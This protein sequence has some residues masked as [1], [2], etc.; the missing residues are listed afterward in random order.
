VTGVKQI[1]AKEGFG[2]LYQ[3]LIPTILKQGSNQGIRFVVYSKYKEV[4]N[5]LT[6]ILDLLTPLNVPFT[7]L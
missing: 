7:H 4:N 5:L 6:P 3:G 2:G 1:V